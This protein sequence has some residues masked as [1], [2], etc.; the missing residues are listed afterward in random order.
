MTWLSGISTWGGIVNKLTELACGE[1]ADGNSVTCAAGDQWVREIGGQNLLRTKTSLDVALGN[2]SNR[3]G[4]FTTMKQRVTTASLSGSML[5]DTGVCRTTNIFTSNPASSFGRWVVRITIS[6]ANTVSGNYSTMTY[7]GTIFDADSGA[8]ITSIGTSSP[9]AAGLAT[10]SNGMQVTFSSPTGFITL[11]QIYMRAFTTTYLGGVDW[12]GP[13]YSRRN[14]SHSFSVNPSGTTVTDWDVVDIPCANSITSLVNNGGM[15]QG[16]GIKTN[17]GLSGALYTV[18]W[19]ASL[20]KIRLI[21]SGTVG[22]INLE[23]GGG[24]KVDT[25]NGSV[26]R[27]QSGCLVGTWLRPFLTAGSVISGS[28]IQYWMSVKPDSI[29]IV[30]NGDPAYTGKSTVA[31][32]VAMTPTSSYDKFPIVYGGGNTDYTIDNSSTTAFTAAGELSLLGAKLRQDASEVRDWQTGWMRADF[33]TT[34]TGTDSFSEAAQAKGW[35]TGA[36]NVTLYAVG[37]Y[38][39]FLTQ[40]VPPYTLPPSTSSKPHLIDGKW[41]LYGFW[42]TENYA[43]ASLIAS[44]G[45]YPRGYSTNPAYV[46]GTG[47]TNADEFTDTATSDVYFLFAAD[48]MGGIGRMHVTTSTYEGG[49]A[50]LEE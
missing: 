2:M 39:D 14:G 7:T 15:A 9:N 32:I 36:G 3:S 16:L 37:F 26:Y 1:S 28:P 34:A 13:Y 18:T 42:W 6:A 43:T 33:T 46:P 27:H 23:C 12:W 45:I 29:I 22:Q 17:T 10:I 8:T 30:L 38:S 25:V 20:N 4:Y 40:P 19:S 48:Y 24:G 21:E 11:N 49:A 35:N 5:P 41:W 47:W 50:I 31:Y 44:T